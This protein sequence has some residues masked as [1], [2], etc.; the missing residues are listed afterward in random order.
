MEERL[1]FGLQH[2]H[3]HMKM[4]SEARI[5]QYFQPYRSLRLRILNSISVFCWSCIR[6]TILLYSLVLINSLSSKTQREVKL[7]PRLRVA[8]RAPGTLSQEGPGVAAR[9]RCFCQGVPEL[10]RGTALRRGQ[11]PGRKWAGAA[12]SEPN[13]G[14]SP[15]PHSPFLPRIENK[16]I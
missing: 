9:W 16:G 5:T 12:P 2:L 15:P 4:H 6:T 11:G 13:P 14:P 3:H 10:A 1:Y 7:E 8:R